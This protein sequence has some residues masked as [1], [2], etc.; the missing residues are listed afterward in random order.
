MEEFGNDVEM[1]TC[2]Q[3]ME[4][5]RG[6]VQLYAS[7]RQVELLDKI[8]RFTTAVT[9]DLNAVEAEFLQAVNTFNRRTNSIK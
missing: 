9:T 6:K 4:A 8:T 1:E 7:C 2:R 3:Q 5:Y